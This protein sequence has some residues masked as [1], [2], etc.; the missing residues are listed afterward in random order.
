MYHQAVKVRDMRTGQQVS[1]DPAILRDNS[2]NFEIAAGLTTVKDGAGLDALQVG[3][4][5]FMSNP[6]LAAN[7]KSAEAAA[8]MLRMM[9]FNDI[10]MF[11]KTEQEKQAEQQAALQQQAQQ[12]QLAQQLQQQQAQTQ[13]TP[14]SAR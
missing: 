11:L 2:L 13:Q 12:L 8:Y 10:D 5:M 3:M 4:Q 7:F 1:I 6:Q 9:G 14:Q